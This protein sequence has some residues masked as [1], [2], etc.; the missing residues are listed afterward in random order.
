MT[1]KEALFFLEELSA[2]YFH[3]FLWPKLR[4]EYVDV[5][6]ED[7]APD[8]MRREDFVEMVVDEKKRWAY[9]SDLANT[10]PVRKREAYLAM[11]RKTEEKFK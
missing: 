6:F 1:V 11:L 9:F 8:T 5:F 2:Q 7:C 10:A 3:C 4:G